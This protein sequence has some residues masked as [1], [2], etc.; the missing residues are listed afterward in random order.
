M[1]GEYWL[2]DA[3]NE[4]ISFPREGQGKLPKEMIHEHMG[5]EG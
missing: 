5:F 4:V 2:N 1:L 3:M